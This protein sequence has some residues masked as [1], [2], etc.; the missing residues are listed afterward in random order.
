MKRQS[1]PLTSVSEVCEFAVDCVNKTAP[2]VDYE[3]P[4]KMIRTSNVKRGFVDTEDVRYVT[5]EVFTKWTRRSLPVPG[6][7]ILTREAPLGEIGRF[8]S[9]DQVMLG[10]R[11]FHYRANPARIHPEFLAYVLQSPEVQ[12]RIRSKGFGAT[13]EHARVGDCENLLIPVPDNLDLQ[14]W[15]GL[16][17]AGFDDLIDNNR[18]RINLLEKAARLIYREWMVRLRFPG[19][20]VA[21]LENG[22]PEGWTRTS[23]GQA[24]DFNPKETLPKSEIRFV[25]MGALSE[26]GMTVDASLTEIRD[27][28]TTVKFRTGDT[29]LARITPCL[30][31]GKTA[32]VGFLGEGEVASGS[33]EF[34]VMRGGKVGPCFTYCLA[35]SEEF[36]GIALASMVGS[37]GRQRAQVS[38]ISEFRLVLPPSH[39]LDDFESTVQPMFDQIWTLVRANDRLVKARDLLLPR[40]MSG[41]IEV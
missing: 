36:R 18:R 33:T 9:E 4:F 6:D 23:V 35:R 34:I 14:E 40:L 8:R 5:E 2:S 26:R 32:Y 22:V 31:N 16:S 3:T 41:E 24:I 30:E 12:G 13:V 37:S 15:I 1:W 28:G 20:E 7:V 39:L 21:K 17:L 11:L 25:P 10:Q 38:V 29:L 19:Y 27:S